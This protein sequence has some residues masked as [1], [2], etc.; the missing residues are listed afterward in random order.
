VSSAAIDFGT[1]TTLIA[2]VDGVEPI[3]TGFDR[4]MPSLIGYGDDGA[5][6]LGEE[7]LG[8]P[9]D[10]RIRSIKRA[11]TERR[12]FVPVDLPSGV[13][14]V[15][16]DDLIGHLLHE[17]ARRAAACGLNLNA[18][19]G[20]RLGCPASWDGR[21]R[22]RLLDA[23]R[24]AGMSLTMESL[25]DEP[26]AAG[27]AWLA[28]RST[29]LP[30]SPAAGARE[31]DAPMR[32][33]AFDMGGGTLDI[34][35]LDVRGANH[36]E[37]SVLAAVG[38]AEGGDALDDSIADDL[39]YMLSRKGV[40]VLALHAPQLAR[41]LLVDAARRVKVS[42]SEEGVRETPIVLDPTVF[43][44]AE[45]WYDRERV[46]AVFQRQMERAEQYV[47]AALRVARLTE[48]VGRSARDVARLPVESLVGDIDVVL[49]S[50]GM[51][52]I[53]YVAERLGW[54][55]PPTTRIERA[56]TP[57]EHAVALGLARAGGYG[58]INMYRPAFDL[59]LEW[60]DGRGFRTVYDAF[61]PLV[62]ASQIASGIDLRFVRTGSEL[63]L[64]R[65][66]SGT[67]RLKSYSDTRVRATIA[68][69]KLDG[70]MVRFGEEFELS[71]YPN[72]R[73][74]IVDGAGAHEGKIEDW[75]T[76]V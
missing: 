65:S 37:V 36:T 47:A 74:R 14:D 25:V 24:R 20:V 66:G 6:V 43:G 41:E 73:L 31:P 69:E 32:L 4:S 26:V 59:V 7:V 48:L 60:E 5:L 11:I 56:A 3:G 13:R 55:F 63:A 75:H 30:A 16:V 9:F 23:A 19:S 40:D 57:P 39:D 27:I 44:P 76:I 68:G 58:R 2:T 61:T 62:E 34:A 45:I 17:A 71:I 53:P 70:F 42:L 21:Q 51:T 52:Q 33:L 67:L 50:G 64:P 35:V 28:T 1:S 10:R 72:G 18:S 22:R 49:L 38:V 46:E 29:E 8:A 54:F 12:D 15:G